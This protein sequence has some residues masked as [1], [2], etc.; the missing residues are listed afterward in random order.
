[1]TNAS[2][3]WMRIGSRMRFRGGG[4]AARNADDKLRLIAKL[5]TPLTPLTSVNCTA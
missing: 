1:M 5:S 2:F 4:C 3:F